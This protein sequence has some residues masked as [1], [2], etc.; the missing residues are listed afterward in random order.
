MTGLSSLLADVTEQARPTKPPLPERGIER[1][2]AQ[3]EDLTDRPFDFAAIQKLLNVAKSSGGGAQTVSAVFDEVYLTGEVEGDLVA[4]V[5]TKLRGRLAVV[6]SQPEGIRRGNAT[7]YNEPAPEPT[8]PDEVLFQSFCHMVRFGLSL[9]VKRTVRIGGMIE[10]P[11][12]TVTFKD[13]TMYIGGEDA[14]T[15]Y[16]K[17]YA[18]TSGA[19][20]QD[21]NPNS[22]RTRGVHADN[23]QVDAAV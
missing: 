14:R 6:S 11:L 20:L 8:D 2:Q 5:E 9:G 17:A 13:G 21:T 10:V 4:Y 12:S 23:Q 7:T 16:T 22:E 15:F 1:I 18:G 3:W 19:D